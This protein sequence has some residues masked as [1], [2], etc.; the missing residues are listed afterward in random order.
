MDQYKTE[1]EN[2]LAGVETDLQGQCNN[3]MDAAKTPVVQLNRTVIFVVTGAQVCIPN[4][5][6]KFG[7]LDQLQLLLCVLCE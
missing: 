7:L 1:I 2:Q 5:S 6:S 4:S 3:K